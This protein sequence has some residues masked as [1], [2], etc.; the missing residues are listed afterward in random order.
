MKARSVLLLMTMY[1]L[2][3]TLVV[4]YFMQS[5]HAE[6]LPHDKV[7]EGFVKAPP[8]PQM[9]RPMIYIPARK[10]FHGKKKRRGRNYEQRFARKMVSVA[11]PTPS[12]SAP[13]APTSVYVGGGRVDLRARDSS[14]K[15]QIGPIC[16]AYAG[17]A[18]IENLLGKD[19]PDFSEEYT[20]SLYG[21]YSVDAFAETV[22][23]RPL[24]LSV[25]WPRGGRQ[26]F[27]FVT[28]NHD[29]ASI[30]YLGD[31]VTKAAKAALLTAHPVYLGLEVPADMASCL[32]SIRPTTKVTSGGHA[33]LIV[34]FVD[35]V[36]NPALGGGYFIIKNSW[37]EAC[38]DHGYQYMP[39]S[40]CDKSY[41][42][43]YEMSKA[44]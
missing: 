35:D 2:M 15:D 30:S 39:Y 22:P 3:M 4:V 44:E 37:S 34:G 6:Y 9:G 33:V 23:G 12:E 8:A 11:S 16:T 29:L 28:T 1:F 43:M 5:V 38:G 20:F 41:C 32:A 24:A 31:G 14:I 17:N 25:Y 40:Y 18:G 27:P 19:S 7:M 21:Q 26:Q 10:M 13:V 42:Y 36:S